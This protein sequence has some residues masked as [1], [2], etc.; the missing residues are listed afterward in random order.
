MRIAIL[1]DW[2]DSALAM[3]DWDSL[4][5]EVTFFRDTLHDE[6]AL[7]ARLAPFDVI[8]LMRERSKMPASVIARLPNLRL[9]VTTG[10]R[11][12]AL[13]LDAAKSQGI[14]VCGTDTRKTTASELAMTLILAM[15]RNLIPQ[16][17]S[18]AAGGWQ[19]G[20]GRDLDG[21]TLGLIGAGAIGA[22]MVERAR[23]FGMQIVAWSQNLTKERC[24]ELDIQRASSL[25]DLMARADAI[26]IHVVL[27]ERTRHLVDKA[28]LA[29][30]KPDGM[31]VNTSR[32]AIVDNQ[33]LLEALRAAP[34]RRAALDVFD[35][36]PLPNS[37][38]VRDTAL[39][40]TGQ[41]LLTPH[42]GYVTEATWRLF[43]QQTVEAIHAFQNGN[44]VR[45]L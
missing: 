23:P 18:I 40:E 5:G 2:A 25:A 36:E 45:Q 27:S 44:P 26:S 32:A 43:Y 24:A 3:A 39:I 38:P 12:L 33:A 14:V 30:M 11:N 9:I 15:A 22:Q 41:L 16:A 20:L 29:A 8:C 35:V 21:M 13:D 42:I 17:Q 34:G 37:D 31:L 10:M 1:D 28:A 7:A 19:R 6:D 4:P